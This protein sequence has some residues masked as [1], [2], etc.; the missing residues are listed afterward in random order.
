MLK[1]IKQR[2]LDAENRIKANIVKLNAVASG[3][4]LKSV[5]AV[6][7]GKRIYIEINQYA[8][9]LEEGRKPTVNGGDGEVL[10]AIKRW[11]KYKGLPEE[12]AY[13]ITKKIHEEGYEAKGDIYSNEIEALKKDIPKIARRSFKGFV[14]QLFQG[15][16]KSK[17]IDIKR[18]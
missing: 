10:R 15:K 16:Y 8:K 1:K 2:L 5:K 3:E 18:I 11:T 9:Y 12:A 13:P 17:N 14:Q 4:L 7:E 6:E